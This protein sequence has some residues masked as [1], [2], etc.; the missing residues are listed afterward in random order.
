MYA[1]TT[2]QFIARAKDKFGNKYGYEKVVY[3][4]AK[5]KVVITCHE[6][7]DFLQSPNMHL[8]SFCVIGCPKCA[9]KFRSDCLRHDTKKF[10]GLGRVIHNNFY[11]YEKTEYVDSKAK[12]V[13]TCPKHG[14]FEQLP[15]NHLRN[16]GCQKC[17]VNKA[18]DEINLGIEEF[19]KRAKLIH[20]NKYDYNKVDYVNK[21]M[22]VS[23]K[24]HKHGYFLQSPHN[25]CSN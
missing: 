4:R 9:N 18:A 5:D 16:H 13:I 1:I 7:G 6:H 24:C 20:D 22:L 2:E 11:S 10:I 21:D 3:T 14:D 15:T 25:H 17:G 23:I 8:G 19:L 12:V